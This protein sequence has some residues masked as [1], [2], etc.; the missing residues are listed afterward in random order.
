MRPVERRA[1]RRAS[2][3]WSPV[4]AAAQ[5]R[6]RR[7]RDSLGGPAEVCHVHPARS[8]GRRRPV[9]RRG[10]WAGGV[11]PAH[12]RLRLRRRGGGAGPRGLR[13]CPPLLLRPL[14]ERSMVL[15]LRRR[16]PLIPRARRRLHLVRHR[17]VLG[18]GR[19]AG[20]GRQRGQRQGAFGRPRPVG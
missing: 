8:R 9:A 4:R 10:R 3:W 5:L 20:R 2:Q 16:A 14:P 6:N 15:R 19:C 12:L 17:S 7:V 13:G 18:L 11:N 1:R